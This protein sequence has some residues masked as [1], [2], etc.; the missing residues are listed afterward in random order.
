M[1]EQPTDDD[2]Q[3]IPGM[4]SGMCERPVPT[5]NLTEAEQAELDRI[6]R[7]V[8]ELLKNQK[9]SRRGAGVRSSNYIAGGNGIQCVT[10]TA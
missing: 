4:P 6:H 9:R 10:S 5:S 2:P 1:S 8:I 7:E 3:Q